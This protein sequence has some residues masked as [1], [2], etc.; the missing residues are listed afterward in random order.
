M[1]RALRHTLLLL[2]LSVV[3]VHAGEHPGR[4]LY[5]RYC[6]AC[7]GRQGHGDGPVA[8]RWERNRRTSR[9]WQ[10]RMVRSSPCKPSSMRSTEPGPCAHMASPRCRY[11]AKCSY[12]TVPHPKRRS[13]GAAR[14]SLSRTISDLCKGCLLPR[15]DFRPS[16]GGNSPSA[17]SKRCSWSAAS[18]VAAFIH[19]GKPVQNAHIESFNGRLRDEC[20]NMHQ[21]VS[22]EDAAEDRGLAPRLRSAA[23]PQRVRAADTERACHP[24]SAERGLP[25]TARFYGR[26]SVS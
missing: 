24:Q 20:L 21:F 3:T 15:T 25:P 26:W 7:H 19:P 18:C 10:R 17:R 1:K 4:Q 13:R 9:S 5:L 6:A 23:A 16:S 12:R 8:R 14:S 11:G 22:L 2:L